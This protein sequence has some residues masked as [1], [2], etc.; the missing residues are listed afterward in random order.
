MAWWDDL[1]LNEGF[2]S[3]MASQDHRRS[4]TRAGTVAARRR[5]STGRA[6]SSRD[7]RASTHPIVQ[8]VETPDQI[9]QAFDAITYQQGRGGDPHA[10][11]RGRARCVPRR[12]AQLHGRSINTATPSPTSY[13]RRSPAASGSDVSTYMHS[14]TLQAGRAA[15]RA[16][17]DPVCGTGG[18]TAINLT[19]SRFGLDAVSKKP[20]TWVVPVNVGAGRIERDDQVAGVGRQ[21]HD[22]DDRRAAARRSSM[23]GRAPISAR[24]TPT[25][26]SKSCAA[27]YGQLKLDDQLGL[28]ADSYGLANSGDAHDRALS[29]ADRYAEARCTSAGL[30]AGDDAVERDRHRCCAA[31][32]SKPRSKPR[33]TGSSRRC[34]PQIGTTARP[35]EEPSATL[36]REGLAPALANFGNPGGD[37]RRASAGASELRASRPGFGGGARTRAQRLCL[38]SDARGLGRSST[39]RRGP[40]PIR[41]P[42]SVIIACSARRRIRRWR[43]A[44]WTW[45]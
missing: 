27:A 8:H 19:Q 28:L 4:R 7:A 15:D 44:R 16:S 37:R 29:G 17:S 43:N 1:W 10:R 22:R 5:R 45:R 35:G 14:F 33:P 41:R 23:P 9:N 21:A 38:C 32:P 42:S 12:R 40:K 25:G 26:I 36:L 39:P 18:Q 30:G 6:R 20:Q 11:R 2:A 3:W 31:H 13:G 24:S 34:W